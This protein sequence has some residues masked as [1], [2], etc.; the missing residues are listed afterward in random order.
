MPLRELYGAQ[1]AIELLRQLLDHWQ[2]YD[3]KDVSGIKL[4]DV[5]IVAAMGPPGI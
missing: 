2:W 3:L 1:P 5:Q 4:V